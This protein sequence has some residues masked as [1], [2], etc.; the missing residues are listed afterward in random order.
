MKH[1]SP[2]LPILAAA[3]CAVALAAQPAAAID[4]TDYAMK[5]DFTVSADYADVSDFP[6]LVRLSANSPVGFS[7]GAC[8]EDGS[9]IA[10]FDTAGTIAYPYEIDTW[11]PSGESLVWV[12]LPSAAK[13]TA[14]TMCY[15]R[16]GQASGSNGA[17][18]WSDYV[19][20]W[21][22]GE[23]SGNA[24][25]ATGNGLN[26]VP[27]SKNANYDALTTMVGADDGVVGR[28]RV[29]CTA[30]GSSLTYMSIPSYD[31]YSVG[32]FT[33]SG[34]FKANAISGAPRPISRKEKYSAAEGFEV[35]FKSGSKTSISVRGSSSKAVVVTLPD[36]TKGWVHLALVFDGTTLSAYTNGAL[37]ISGAIDTVIDKFG[38]EVWL[39]P[40]DDYHFKITVPVAVRK[41]TGENLIE[42]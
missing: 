9:D 14:F 23:A 2:T 20:V 17:A 1:S 19:G 7:Y 31:S 33:I 29:N 4:F 12:R 24:I 8:A 11:N 37:S 40:V 3:L 42:H 13:N 27:T 15:G 39:S 35:S 25:D 16:S 22:M 18:V 26:G 30:N 5:I 36:V 28:S 21:H 34:W 41:G 6:V 38:K 10:F 32:V